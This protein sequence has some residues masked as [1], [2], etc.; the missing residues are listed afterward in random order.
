MKTSIKEIKR[1]IKLPLKRLHFVVRDSEDLIKFV[2]LCCP[3]TWENLLR[4]FGLITFFVFPISSILKGVFLQGAVCLGI[5]KHLFLDF[6]SL[7]GF[8][9]FVPLFY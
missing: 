2:L 5:N 7:A 9:I 6:V 8:L 3:S 4:Y 1:Q